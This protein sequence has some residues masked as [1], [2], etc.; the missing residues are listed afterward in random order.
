MNYLLAVPD[1]EMGMAFSQNIQR[2]LASNRDELNIDTLDISTSVEGVMSFVKEHPVH[3]LIALRDIG[4]G[5]EDNFLA[6]DIE[7]LLKIHPDM[8]I[9]FVVPDELKGT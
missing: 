1:D 8:R 3:V 6:S 2:T 9:I 4:A 7:K 5:K